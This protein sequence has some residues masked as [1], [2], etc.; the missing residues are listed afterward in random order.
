MQAEELFACASRT[1]EGIPAPEV[2]GETMGDERRSSDEG[3]RRAAALGVMRRMLRE[4]ENVGDELDLGRFA[5]ASE[6]EEILRRAGGR[7]VPWVPKV[8]VLDRGASLVVRVE[9]PGVNKEDVRVSVMDDSLVVEGERRE[10]AD[11]ARST[12]LSAECA[13][14]PFRRV[15]PLPP[16]ANAESAEARLQDGVLEVSLERSSGKGGRRRVEIE[17]GG[18]PEAGRGR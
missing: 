12:T 7:D 15:I 4:W 9:L 16:G 17:D 8:E 6:R 10:E 1:R 11:R 5:P 14:G 2:E 3:L 13:C 18:R